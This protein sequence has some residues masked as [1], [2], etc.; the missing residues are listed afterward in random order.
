MSQKGDNIVEDG[1]PA[2]TWNKYESKNPVQRYLVKN[3]LDTFRRAAAPLAK[4]CQSAI[5]VGCGEGVS[6]RLLKDV[7]FE[8]IVG[9]DFSKQIIE[10]AKSENPDIE[11]KQVDI[12]DLDESHSVDFV[13]ACE[14]FEHL[15]G[16]EKALKKLAELCRVGGIVSVP[17]EPIFRMLN[18]AAFKYMRDFGNSPGHLNHWSSRGI[19]RF[20]STYFEIEAVY[21]PLPWTIVVVRPKR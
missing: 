11:F 5:D 6:T 20:L 16:P 21:R 12:F 19:V 17:N 2:G 13:S 8:S 14:V 7:G 1:I 15:E 10:T 4:E 3:F 9:L 18:F